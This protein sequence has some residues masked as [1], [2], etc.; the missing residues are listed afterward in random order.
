MMIFNLQLFAKKD[1][2]VV[3]LERPTYTD[4]NKPA[5]NTNISNTAATPEIK[6]VDNSLVN[7][8][9]SKFTESDALSSQKQGVT[10]KANAYTNF[11]SNTNIISS[12]VWA[13]LTTPYS[14]SSSV[15]QAEQLL[16]SKIDQGYAGTHKD[17]LNSLLNDFMNREDFEYD[18]DNDQMFQQALASA[19]GSG[20]TAMQ[21]TMG[22][23]AALTGGYG[24]TYATSAG[25]QAYNAFIQDAYDNLPEYYNMALAAY[26]A[27]GQ[28]MLQQYNMLDAADTKEYSQWYDD[29]NFQYQRTRDMVNDE[30]NQWNANQTMYA[31]TANMQL[32]ENAQVGNNLYNMYNVASNEY[33]NAYTKEWNNWQQSVNNAYNLAGLQSNDYWNT[34]DDEFR[35]S[36]SQREQSNWQAE[37]DYGKERDKVGD[38][39]WQQQFDYNKTQDEQSQSNWEKS[40]K[41]DLANS[42]ATVDKDGNV[43]IKNNGSK[44]TGTTATDSG[45]SPSAQ[46]KADAKKAYEEGGTKGLEDYVAGQKD[47][48]N[49]DELLDYVQRD[50]L[51]A[52]TTVKKTNDTWNGFLGL[53]GAFGGVDVD[54]TFEVTY[55]NEDGTTTTKILKTSELPKGAQ[56]RANKLKKGESAVW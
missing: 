21:D 55:T 45:Y 51:P 17:A 29:I 6:G 38:K 12:D 27:E 23:A 30:Y 44:G 50:S 31:N 22:Q 2:K 40:Y 33:E 13:G 20:K 3:E 52:G 46:Q 8:M 18:V 14:K 43:T 39:Q 7:T 10:D 1:E 48:M 54:D 34:K 19:M 24:S 26:E 49:T 36:E 4:Q 11:A 25:N 5:T 47:G 32:S 16:Q 42:G 56:V 28:Q 37:F 15:L 9:N 35:V 41:L 53:R